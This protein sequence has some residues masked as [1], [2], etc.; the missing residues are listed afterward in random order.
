[1]NRYQ[2]ALFD[3]DGTM[4]DT[5]GDMVNALNIL[6]KRYKKSP[7]PL[8]QLRCYVSNGTPALLKIGFGCTPNSSN[9]EELKNQFLEIYEENVCSYTVLFSGMEKIL[10]QCEKT[11]LPWGI[12]TNKPEYLTILVLNQLG[13]SDLVACL[14]GGDTISERKPSPA[15]ILHA[16][17]M[18]DIAPEH[19]VY[20]GDSSRDIDAGKAAGVETVA[21]AYGYILPGDDPYGWG[22]HYSVDTVGDIAHR[23]WSN[24]T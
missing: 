23:L 2:L 22:A 7:L 19:S 16:C 14:V 3:F 9:F 21:A 10:E 11:N 17:S 15:P 8:E 4:A 18:V 13:L 5:A 24:H 12:V 6:L 1:M 20:I